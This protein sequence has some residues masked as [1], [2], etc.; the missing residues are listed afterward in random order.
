M[1]TYAD[2]RQ[3]L[4]TDL[5]VAQIAL[6][7]LDHL[8]ARGR[9]KYGKGYDRPV[10]RARLCGRIAELELNLAALDHGERVAQRS[11]ASP[12]L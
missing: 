3:E 6:V 7:A 10:H 11:T 12:T 1:S 4:E 9:A 8:I 5:V 2:L